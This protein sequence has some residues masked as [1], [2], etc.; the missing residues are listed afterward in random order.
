[1]FGHATYGTYSNSILPCKHHLTISWVGIDNIRR[2]LHLTTIYSLWTNDQ[3][4]ITYTKCDQSATV[5]R[6][7]YS[8]LMP[9]LHESLRMVCIHSVPNAHAQ[10]YYSWLYF[11]VELCWVVC[12][13]YG[14]HIVLEIAIIVP[15]KPCLLLDAWT[16]ESGMVDNKLFFVIPAIPTCLPL[17]VV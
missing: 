13:T 15:L 6:F 11:D 5:I 8:S 14:M 16:W 1:M 3:L 9:I 2:G 10:L 17:I 7:S 4:C 12:A